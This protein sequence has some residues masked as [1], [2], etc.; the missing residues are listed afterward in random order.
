MYESHHLLLCHQ[1]ITQD[2]CPNATQHLSVCISTFQLCSCDGLL[3]FCTESFTH[4]HH[5][6]IRELSSSV[7]K[8]G[9]GCPI[10]TEVFLEFH[11]CY[12]HRI[13]RNRIECQLMGECIDEYNYGGITMIVPLI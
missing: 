4:R 11:R 10:L 12:F 9:F 7:G 3:V 13:V 5:Y 1:F 8:K 6:L 2:E